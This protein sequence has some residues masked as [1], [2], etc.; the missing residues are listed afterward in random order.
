MTA[1]PGSI[2]RT[3][4]RLVLHTT[5]QPGHTTVP[6]LR[7]VCRQVLRTYSD[8]DLNPLTARHPW[9]SSWYTND[10]GCVALGGTYNEDPT[11]FLTDRYTFICPTEPDIELHDLATAATV[12]S[13]GTESELY[14]VLETRLG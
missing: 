11:T 9:D 13:I 14:M 1:T 7:N 8:L 4:D 6:A 10:Q 3:L 5:T 12:H 2:A